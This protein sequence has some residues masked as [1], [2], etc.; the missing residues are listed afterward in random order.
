M[1]L[2]ADIAAHGALRFDCPHCAARFEVPLAEFYGPL[3]ARMSLGTP[4]A[5]AEALAGVALARTCGACARPMLL[6]LRTR[7]HV[8]YAAEASARLDPDALYFEDGSTWVAPL[9]A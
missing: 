8:A 5:R 2:P 9:P 6:R 3:S 7:V 1:T 4:L